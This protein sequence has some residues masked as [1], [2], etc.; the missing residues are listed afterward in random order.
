MHV[1]RNIETR[2]RNYRCRDKERSIAHSECVFVALV[3][4]HA[5]HMPVLYRHL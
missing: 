2:S 3:V 4:Q 1:K 5:K